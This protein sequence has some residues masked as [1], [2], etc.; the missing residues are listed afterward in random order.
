MNDRS[1]IVSDG[2]V[3]VYDSYLDNLV[4]LP[5]DRSTIENLPLARKVSETFARGPEKGRS[6][7]CSE[8]SEDAVTWSAFRTLEKHSNAEKWVPWFW[9]IAF[10][11]SV[12]EDI[13]GAFDRMSISY[14]EQ[15]PAPALRETR[16]G[17]TQVDVTIKIG[18]A[19]LVFIEAKLF[20]G[21]SG[22]TKHD[23]S[24]D[25]VIRN[26]DVGSRASKDGKW[27]AERFYF[28][29][30]TPTRTGDQPGAEL[31]NRYRQPDQIRQALRY[32]KDLSAQDCTM[33]ARNI[34]WISW[35][36]MLKVAL[37]ALT[38]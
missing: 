30:L 19:A 38:T 29:A 31:I 34:G 13:R 24:R 28:V 37:R 5:E 35:P 27:S 1:W 22:S 7:L 2:N 3:R 18:D 15:F 9:E 8:N 12:P 11:E 25:Q 33:L 23:E 21:F 16:E 20:S 14:W 32:R 26:I 17:S 36:D 4:L 10:R 6:R